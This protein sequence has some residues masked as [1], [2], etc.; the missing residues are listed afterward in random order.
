MRISD[1][2]PWDMRP[3]RIGLPPPPP[4]PHAGREILPGFT[5]LTCPAFG[6]LLS[7]FLIF[8]ACENLNNL[9]ETVIDPEEPSSFIGDRGCSTLDTSPLL[10]YSF[11]NILQRE[12]L[13]TAVFR[14][15]F[16]L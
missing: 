5:R 16:T 6:A 15:F 10:N 8:T 11:H 3:G 9:M 4:P 2:I 12:P 14:S 1:G 13:K 7:L